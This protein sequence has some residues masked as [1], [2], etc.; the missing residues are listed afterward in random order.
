MPPKAPPAGLRPELNH[1]DLPAG[2]VVWRVSHAD[3]VGPWS[4]RVAVDPF[5]EG[6]FDPVPEDPFPYCYAALTDTAALVER[7]L[8]DCD[9]DDD[10]ARLMPAAELRHKRLIS[11][12]TTRVVRLISLRT[13]PDLAAACQDSWLVHAESVDHARTRYW[14]RWLRAA[15]PG[16]G[17]LIW[18]SKRDLGAEVVMFFGD[19]DRAGDALA[20]G[21]VAARELDTV[22]GAAWL[23]ERLR[24]YRAVVGRPPRHC[25]NGSPR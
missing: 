17:G 21:P 18:P 20:A 16:A 14:G 12:R 2:T 8:R 4:T 19:R 24:P 9:F 23:R 5:S 1:C 3:A 10:G 11:L 6:R 13:G 22:D 7:L 25:R 15:S